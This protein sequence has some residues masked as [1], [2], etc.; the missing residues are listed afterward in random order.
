MCCR[1]DAATVPVFSLHSS[2]RVNIGETF[3][4]TGLGKQFLFAGCSKMMAWV[5]M[6]WVLPV[7]T[8]CSLAKQ[9]SVTGCGGGWQLKGRQRKRLERTCFFVAFFEALST[10]FAFKA[11]HVHVNWAPVFNLKAS[12]VSDL[13]KGL[14]ASIRFL[15]SNVSLS[16]YLFTSIASPILS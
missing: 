10:C 3:L 1:Q 16:S 15:C 14:H 2:T 8:S 11:G 5:P 13:K 9:L 6:C 4:H 12:C 7:D